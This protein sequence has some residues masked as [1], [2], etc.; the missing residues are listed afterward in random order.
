MPLAIN[1]SNLSSRA[2]RAASTSGGVR[3]I[4]VNATASQDREEGGLGAIYNAIEKFGRSLMSFA[5]NSLKGLFTFSWAKLWQAVVGGVRYLLNFNI[6]MN[7]DQ[8]EA[9][10]KRAEI[11]LAASKGALVGQSLGFAVCGIVPT[12]TIAVFNEPLALYMLKELGEEGAE[13]I[14][15]SLAN[16]VT[17]QIQQSARKGFLALFKNHRSLVRGAAIGFANMLVRVGVLDQASVDK[18]NQ[19]RNKPWSIASALEDSIESIKD[20]AEQA[21]VEEFWEEFGDSCI[22]AGYILASSADSYFAQ[23][24][25]ANESIFGTE[26]VIEIQPVRNADEDD[27]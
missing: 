7:D 19:E 17:L 8:I 16:L 23:Q 12:A 10:I 3:R 6:N 22:E 20:P 11:A 4:A 9:Q 2:I 5:F 15:A 26:R 21:Y 13:E 14:A 25:M 1:L 18:A 27:S 24:R